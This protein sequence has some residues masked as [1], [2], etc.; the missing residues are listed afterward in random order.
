[1][2]TSENDRLR[3]YSLWVRKD[4]NS[5]SVKCPTKIK[6]INVRRKYNEVLVKDSVF[7]GFRLKMTTQHNYAR[8]D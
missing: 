3:I 1:V 6:W 4:M 5:G 7:W 8:M 2:A